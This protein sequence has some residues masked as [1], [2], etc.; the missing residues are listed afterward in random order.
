MAAVLVEAFQTARHHLH[1][2]AGT[3][4][5]T[6]RRAVAWHQD[7]L[8]GSSRGGPLRMAHRRRLGC[9]VA[10]GRLTR[11]AWSWLLIAPPGE[12]VFLLY[13]RGERA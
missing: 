9:P 6:R 5:G 12:P 8:V 13:E 3:E 11:D 2:V 10:P 1:S 4:V 7:G